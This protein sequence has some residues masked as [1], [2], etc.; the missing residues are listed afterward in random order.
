M[1]LIAPDEQEVKEAHLDTIK[2]SILHEMSLYSKTKF[3]A[4]KSDE[5]VLADFKKRFACWLPMEHI[6]CIFVHSLE[7]PVVEESAH[8]EDDQ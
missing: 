2:E 1:D 8:E 3:D 4:G 6:D 5:E 7:D